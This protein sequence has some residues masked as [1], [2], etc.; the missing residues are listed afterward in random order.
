MEMD[1]VKPKY[2]EEIEEHIYNKK[3]LEDG[4]YIELPN[5]IVSSQQIMVEL[6]E[7]DG[8]LL[9]IKDV[10]F[11]LNGYR[12]IKLSL[13]YANFYIYNNP[14]TQ[15]TLMIRSDKQDLSTIGKTTSQDLIDAI[16]HKHNLL[17]IYSSVVGD[18]AF[19]MF[20]PGKDA[21]EMLR[22]IGWLE[23]VVQ[24]DSHIVPMMYKEKNN[25]YWFTILLSQFTHLVEQR[26]R[27]KFRK[28]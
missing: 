5:T 24:L 17:P 11:I 27:E 18:F 6:V 12:L 14:F 8:K 26:I 15:T 19:E 23:D 28:K 2:I 9:S 1:L 10:S 16:R 7:E 3:D 21:V 4:E 22:G 25:Y 13:V 20:Y